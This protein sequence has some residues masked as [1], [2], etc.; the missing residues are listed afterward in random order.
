MTYSTPRVKTA[1]DQG[2]KGL[3]FNGQGGAGFSR[4]ANPYSGNKSGLTAKENYGR[5]PTVAGRTGKMAGPSEAV[6]IGKKVNA[7]MIN[8][9][10]GPRNAGGTREAK[11]PPNADSIN[12][13]RGPVKG[14]Q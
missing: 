10:N 3:D 6:S 4:G 1:R 8:L 14:N 13:G 5:G 2:D 9:G 11:C 7:D 12:V